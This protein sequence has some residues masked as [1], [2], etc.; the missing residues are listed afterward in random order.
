MFAPLIIL[1][2]DPRNRAEPHFNCLACCQS[3]RQQTALIKI[4]VI[5]HLAWDNRPVDDPECRRL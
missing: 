5:F 4:K 3:A 2:S 1:E